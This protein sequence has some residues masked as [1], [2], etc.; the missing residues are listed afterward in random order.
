MSGIQIIGGEARG[1][2]LKTFKEGDLS[3]RPILA[4]IKKSLFDI[5]APKLAGARFLDL[6]AGTG[7]VGIEALSRGAARV[8]FVESSP[9][10]LGLV[11]QNLAMLHWES[12]AVVHR[13]DIAGG[14]AWLREQFDIIFMGPPYKDAEKRP[15]ALTG[16]TLRFIA[17]ARLLAPGGWIIGQH[18]EKEPV[19]VPE[20]LTLFRREKY[21]DTYL[22][23]FT[24]A[25][26]AAD[27]QE[28]HV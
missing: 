15:L 11:R 22:S 14:L 1:R 28:P 9:R 8:V 13:A 7:A 16:M 24:A 26:A 5:L 4:R 23:F 2:F 10:S 20:G 19:D 18:H 12:R 25:P 17:E 27:H 6:F 3:V 21:G